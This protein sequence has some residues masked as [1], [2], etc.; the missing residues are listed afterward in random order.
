MLRLKPRDLGYTYD[1]Y[2]M[3]KFSNFIPL[4]NIEISAVKIFDSIK[5]ELFEVEETYRKFRYITIL[6]V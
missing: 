1:N 3:R 5:Q 4:E 2:T 6:L